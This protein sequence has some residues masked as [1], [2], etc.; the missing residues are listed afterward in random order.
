VSLYLPVLYGSVRHERKSIHVAKYVARRLGQRPGVESR[1]FDPRDLPFGNLAQRVWE[2]AD[3]PPAVD[4]FVQEMGRADGFVIVTP[5]YNF[6][7]PGTLKNMLD[8]LHAPW[9]NKPFGLV[10]AGG[11]MGGARAIDGLRLVIPGVWGVTV[12][13]AVYV[14]HVES[15]FTEEGPAGDRKGWDDRFEEF[16]A[17]VEWYADALKA[18]RAVRPPPRP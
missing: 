18:A 6:G 9:R 13:L 12:P 1:L 2:W 15:A 11:I 16:F 3:A 8:H 5:E 17:E 10:G 7:Y 14:H 4:E